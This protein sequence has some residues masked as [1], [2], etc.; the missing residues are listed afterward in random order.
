ME[1]N[2]RK[3]EILSTRDIAF[4]LKNVRLTKLS[5]HQIFYGKIRNKFTNNK[6][7]Y[8]IS[9]FLNRKLETRKQIIETFIFL[10]FL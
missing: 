6:L 5:G 7:P 3:I 2:V 4:F 8:I 10:M 1:I 9:S